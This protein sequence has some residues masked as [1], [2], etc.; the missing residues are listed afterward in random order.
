[1]TITLKDQTEGFLYKGIM[2]VQDVI[3]RE[4]LSMHDTS[5]FHSKLY[6]EKVLSLRNVTT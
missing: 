4:K 1:M 3:K 5:Y 6:G 2:I